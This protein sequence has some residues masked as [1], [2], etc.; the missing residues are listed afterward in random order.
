MKRVLII[1]VFF[2]TTMLFTGCNSGYM[3]DLEKM[4]ERVSA[5]ESLCEQLNTNVASLQQLIS[6]IQSKDLISGIT[7][8]TENGKEVGYKINFFNSP[9][10][11]ILNGVSGQT[12]LIG[13]KK[14]TDELYYW[15]I[16]YDG[17]DV[18]WL[19]N[20]D[21]EKILAMG[22]TPFFK[23]T[24]GKWY[25]SYDL[26][27]TYTEIG[28]ATGNSGD[29]M[30]ESIDTSDPD[31]VLITLSNGTVL[32]IPTA[33]AY[34]AL[35]NNVSQINTNTRSLMSIVDAIKDDWTY[36]KSVSSIMSEGEE[37][38]TSIKLS[39]D[40]TIII[41]HWT[42]GSAPTLFAKKDVTNNIY[43]WAIQYIGENATWIT[44]ENGEKIKAF[45]SQP[46]GIP[47]VGIKELNGYYYWTIK[48][49]E[50]GTVNYLLNT[51]GDKIR[52]IDS[53]RNSIFS[54]INNTNPDYFKISI[55]S[56]GV[57]YDYCLPKMY[58]VVLTSSSFSMNVNSTATIGYTVYGADSNISINLIC[59]GK[60][61]ASVVP[62]A[63]TIGKGNIIINSPPDFNNGEG[64]IIML[65]NAGN[66]STKTTVKSIQ[67]SNII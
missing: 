14:D 19:T 58:S 12:P 25:I 64:K 29:S 31:F 8:I 43:Y 34:E 6:A 66:G 45:G 52:A 11:T 57:N 60:F 56:G 36:V 65:V 2:I 16:Q 44:G 50:E 51:E 27:K 61:R 32:K 28:Q 40:S 39:N 13:S 59:Q 62:T 17:G 1:I 26:G 46:E 67:I 5:L 49:G 35:K 21:G 48:Y 24:D 7:S 47:I 3:E 63:G 30:F 54:G 55:S 33:A 10:I 38:G 42:S 53:I 23:I 37:I 20:S 9:S 22:I 15:T 4:K 18:E 41:Y